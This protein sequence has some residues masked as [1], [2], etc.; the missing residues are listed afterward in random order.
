MDLNDFYGSGDHR[1]KIS[2]ETFEEMVFS[3]NLKPCYQIFLDK[4]N[5]IIIN[6]EWSSP[7]SDNIKANR[8]YKFDPNFIDL[9]QPEDRNIVLEDILK[10]YVDNEYFEM[11]AN[12]IHTIQFLIIP[13]R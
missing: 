2:L 11:A 10:I 9:I 4:D 5:D 3:L 8:I 6:E 13:L 1:D 7:V 12:Y